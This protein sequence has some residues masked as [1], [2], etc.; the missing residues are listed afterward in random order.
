MLLPTESSLSQAKQLLFFSLFFLLTCFLD[1]S[2]IR[3]SLLEWAHSIPGRPGP[4]K[5]QQ[6]HLLLLHFYSFS[7][8]SKPLGTRDSPNHLYVLCRLHLPNSAAG[9]TKCKIVWVIFEARYIWRYELNVQG[10]CLAV[11]ADQKGYFSCLWEAI[12]T[13]Y[14]HW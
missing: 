6:H 4:H 12:H 11:P 3:G 1:P 8:D 5:M 10:A 7:Q 14:Q 2:P 9:L 13:L